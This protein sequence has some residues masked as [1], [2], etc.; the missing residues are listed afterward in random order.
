M[1]LTDNRQTGFCVQGWLKADP[2]ENTSL[3]KGFQC[4]DPVA[5]KRRA[6]LPLAAE[7]IIQAGQSGS[8]RI[9]A[10]AVQV[11]EWQ[12]SIAA[13]GQGAEGQAVGL[14]DFDSR[15]GQRHVEWVKRIRGEREHNLFGYAEHFVLDGVIAQERKKVWAGRGSCVKV[16]AV[17]SQNRG[18]IAISAGVP[19]PTIGVSRKR[20][21]FSRLPLGGIDNGAS[22]NGYTVRI[23]TGIWWAPTKRTIGARSF[24]LSGSG[25]LTTL[26]AHDRS[27]IR[28]VEQIKLICHSRFL[29]SNYTQPVGFC[30]IDEF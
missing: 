23:E 16:V 2:R 19:A 17:H 3:V 20:G 10:G 21:V 29:Q 28:D 26:A 14:D 22:L 18:N 12:G 13:F 4:G 25:G 27:G 24:R 7:G 11:Q 6:A 30:Q 1:C 8:K 15:T 9:T 5:R